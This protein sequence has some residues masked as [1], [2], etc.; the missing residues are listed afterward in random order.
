MIRASQNPLAKI[1]Q[2][3]CMAIILYMIGISSEKNIMIK[4]KNETNLHYQF[5]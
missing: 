5:P 3:K 2:R 1:K 4:T